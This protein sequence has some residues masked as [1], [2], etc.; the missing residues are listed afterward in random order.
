M[1]RERKEMEGSVC[2]L[3]VCL[4]ILLRFAAL[5]CV[6]KVGTQQLARADVLL[7]MEVRKNDHH[8][9]DPVPEL[10]LYGN[11]SEQITATVAASREVKAFLKRT[12]VQVQVQ[13]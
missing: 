1:G 7:E 10:P 8:S 4:C 9:P 11:L 3:C 13:V 12:Q 2:D 5:C 6:V